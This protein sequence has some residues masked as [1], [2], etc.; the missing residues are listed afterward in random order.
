[1]RIYKASTLERINYNAICKLA[2]T[3]EATVVY[4]LKQV[5]NA[6]E[7]TLET[8][9]TTKLN[10][11]VGVLR[12]ANGLVKFMNA[13][14]GGG[15]RTRNADSVSQATSCNSDYRMNKRYLTALRGKPT[16]YD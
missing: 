6:I 2:E 15:H 11:K 10:F 7:H 12:F 4:I 8:G 16:A 13:Q 1:M 5:V 3:P 9:Y 14:T